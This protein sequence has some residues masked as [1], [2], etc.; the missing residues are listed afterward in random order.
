MEAKHCLTVFRWRL[1]DYCSPQAA[2]KSFMDWKATQDLVLLVSHTS[3]WWWLEFC[4][5]RVVTGV[6]GSQVPFKPGFR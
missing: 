4:E 2:E 3:R 6:T 1:F 5:H